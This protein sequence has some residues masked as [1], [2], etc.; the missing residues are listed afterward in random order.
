MEHHCFST[1]PNR[2]KASSA[3]L[4]DVVSNVRDSDYASVCGN[5]WVKKACA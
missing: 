4:E 2:S 3:G 5:N 1:A